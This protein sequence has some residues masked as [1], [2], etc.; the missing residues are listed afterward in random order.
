MNWG[1]LLFRGSYTYKKGLIVQSS[2]KTTQLLDPHVL[3]M[4]SLKK[5]LLTILSLSLFIVLAGNYNVLAK[6]E[7]NG[8]NSNNAC[9]VLTS[10]EPML[11]KEYVNENGETVQH[12][13]DNT[14][15]VYHE[16]GTIT[17]YSPFG[18][19]PE[20]EDMRMNW[21][22]IGKAILKFVAGVISACSSYDYVTG[23]D[24]CRTV[25]RYIPK[26]TKTEY[27]V[28]GLYHPGRI[29][30]C[31]PSNSLPCNSGYWEYRVY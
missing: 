8:E 7:E 15:V 10:E 26:P 6:M 9:E 4:Q 2:S 31:E 24:I 11:N 5:K 16:D 3:C 17:V 22:A 29:P 23:H 20:N 28:D 19:K 14:Q 21:I 12:F 13:E 18:P 1:F 25:L 27:S 30:G